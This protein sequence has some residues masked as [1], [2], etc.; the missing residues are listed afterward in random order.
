MQKLIMTIGLPGCGKS[1]FANNIIKE[2]SNFI[3]VERDTLRKELYNTYKLSH[4]QEK[5]IT[6]VQEERILN[7]LKKGQSVIISD[8][9]L[10]PKTIEKW[11]QFII[12]FNIWKSVDNYNK[13]SDVQCIKYE[14]NKKEN[15]I[16]CW[17][18]YLD[19]NDL[20]KFYIE[21]KDHVMYE[22]KSF[23]DV[24]IDICIKQD[25]QRNRSVGK[26]VIMEKHIKYVRPNLYKHDSNKL[27]K[28]KAV[29][30]DI[31]GTLSII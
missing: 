5:E 1:F 3:K 27:N 2:D 7:A 18:E 12:D 6:K 19:T 16:V 30:F 28:Q 10:N 4:T 22:E 20:K 21:Y 29:I 25:L 11:K 23:L 9:N 15:Q 8:T 13:A 24:P 17:Y 31:D 14:Y 26:D